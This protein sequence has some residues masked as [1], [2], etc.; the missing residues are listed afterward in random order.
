MSKLSIH[1]DHGKKAIELAKLGY[2]ANYITSELNASG[3]K[4]HHTTVKRFLTS[5]KIDYKSNELKAKQDNYFIESEVDIDTKLDLEK[6]IKK[7]DLDDNFDSIDAILNNAQK[8]ITKIFYLHCI[9]LYAKLDDFSEG[10]CKYPREFFRNYEITLNALNLAYGISKSS[11]IPKAIKTL[12]IGSDSDKKEIDIDFVKK[13]RLE[14][15]GL[16]N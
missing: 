13:M 8:L 7:L 16:E 9:V 1:S 10:K 11:N 12:E 4:V 6:I 5:Q 14:I 2:S 3:F 15:Y